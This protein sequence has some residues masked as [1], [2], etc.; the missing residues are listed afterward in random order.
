M[1]IRTIAKVFSD[2]DWRDD[3]DED[4]VNKLEKLVNRTKS[5]EDAYKQADDPALAQLWVGMAELFYQMERMNKR[6]RKVEEQQRQL[7]EDVDKAEGLDDDA[8][9]DS[10][11]NY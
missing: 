11:D 9:R 7:I 3:L 6:L 5:Y 2:R 1:P 4:L 8:L 10:M